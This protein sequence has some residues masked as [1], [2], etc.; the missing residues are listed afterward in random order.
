MQ[1]GGHCGDAVMLLQLLLGWE[2]L[3]GG[4]PRTTFALESPVDTA[5]GLPD[6]WEGPGGWG[7]AVMVAALVGGPSEGERGKGRH[8]WCEF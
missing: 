4:L 6:P 3:T 1:S 2:L 5:Y 8:W 7:V